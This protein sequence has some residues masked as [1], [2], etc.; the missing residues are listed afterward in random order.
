MLV[1]IL[2]FCACRKKTVTPDYS[3]LIVGKWGCDSY[4]KD[5]ADTVVRRQPYSLANRYENG[6]QF[7]A[8]K[9]VLYRS[10]SGDWLSFEK[11]NYLLEEDKVLTLNQVDANSVSSKLT[12]Q[13]TEF[14]A[15]KLTVHS[16]MWKSTFFL[17]KEP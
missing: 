7:L 5:D 10:S 15:N 12:F 6:W 8:D 2:F 9:K 1:T 4:K 13:I 3:A 17:T 11:D 14:T 16:D